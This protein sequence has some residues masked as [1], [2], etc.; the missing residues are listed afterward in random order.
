MLA[1]LRNR[2]VFMATCCCSELSQTSLNLSRGLLLDLP[3]LELVVTASIVRPTMYI[4][5]KVWPS[6]RWR[7]SMIRT[8]LAWRATEDQIFALCYLIYLLLNKVCLSN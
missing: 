1:V 8:C 2:C 4:V 7:C 3:V 6:S 5:L